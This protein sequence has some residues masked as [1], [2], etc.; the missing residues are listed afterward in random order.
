M[1]QQAGSKEDAAEGQDEDDVHSA[2][3]QPS[4]FDA[5]DNVAPESDEGIVAHYPD[6]VGL[7]AT[8]HRLDLN[9]WAALGTVPGL[10][11]ELTTRDFHIRSLGSFS[12]NVNPAGL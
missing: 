1:L 9:S 11:P 3:R 6:Q 8:L 7:T 5:V 4:D 2:G 10:H 12:R